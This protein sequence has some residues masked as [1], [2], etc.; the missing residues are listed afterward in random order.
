MYR[1]Y[2]SYLEFLRLRQAGARPTGSV[3][4]A[5]TAY[6]SCAPTRTM[7]LTIGVYRSNA[8]LR[9]ATLASLEPL[10]DETKARHLA[11]LHRSRALPVQW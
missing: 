7:R 10:S 6:Y 1:Q 3:G 8:N 4:Y 5:V 9:D 2:T 11:G